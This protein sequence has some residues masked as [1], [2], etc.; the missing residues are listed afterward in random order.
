VCTIGPPT[1]TKEGIE[2]LAAAGMNVARFNM[3][4]GDHAWHQSVIDLVDAY[5]RDHPEAMIG[6][7]LDTKGPEVRSGDVKKPLDLVPG[8]TLVFDC[9][10]GATHDGS[11]G[12]VGV[13]YDDF[14]ND[15]DVSDV[16]LVDGG[17]M[18]MRV[19]EKDNA[20]SLVKCTIIEGGKM[21]S[22]RH[23][24]V[25]GRSA[26]LPSLTD[27]DWDDIKFGVRNNV[28]FFALSFVKD[29]EVVHTLRA[30]LKTQ[31]ANTQI[32]PKIE[33]ADSVQNLEEILRA[34]DGCM[35]ARGDLGAELPVEQVPFWQSAIVQGLRRL[36]KPVIVA[37]NMLE[38][39][40]ENPTPTRAEV[41]DISIAVREGTDAVMLSGE[42]AYGKYPA[43][44]VNVMATVAQRT[45]HAMSQEVGSRRNGSQES[46]PITWIQ[47]T[48][49]NAETSVS[50]MFAF[51]ATTMANTLGCPILVF[52]RYGNMPALLSHYRPD[53]H[54][55][56]FCDREDVTRRLSLYNG[57]RASIFTLGEDPDETID[58]AL[59]DLVDR[60][61]LAPSDRICV[62]RGGRRPLWRS[63]ATHAI[64]VRAA[65]V[66]GSAGIGFGAMEDPALKYAS[67]LEGPHDEAY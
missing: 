41:S 44:A 46:Y 18:T 22:R 19:D 43:R 26:S 31:G 49:P 61:E 64:Q 14:I 32:M 3:S 5:N 29:A 56:A 38:S 42:T 15:V 12:V 55:F 4:H 45:E 47:Q 16:I 13:N 52:S 57:V 9:A 8:A 63:N 10:D 39:M 50:E 7:L 54:I 28:D 6:K 66:D 60:G 1:A 33:S 11:E 34:S 59:R 36:G 35:V 62:V 65:V 24:N 2:M 40:I 51:H 37:T 53:H 30:W 21:G 27:K 17:L 23:L 67:V 25:R 48:D 20:N 58:R